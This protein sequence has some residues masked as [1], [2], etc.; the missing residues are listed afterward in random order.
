MTR[1]YF[2]RHAEAMGN[3]REFFQ[4]R[5]DCD[6]SEKGAKQLEKLAERFKTV[7]YDV[8]YS[9]PLIRT[10][11]TAEA[12]NSRLKL[13]IIKDERLIEINGGV[14]EGRKWTEIAE[15]Y[16]K[17]HDTWKNN[18][19]AFEIEDGETMTEVYERMKAAV[20][21]IADKNRGKTVVIVSH[22]CALRNYLSFAEFG[23]PDG[24]SEVGW[25]D[26]TAVSLIEYDDDLTPT[27]IYKNDSSHLP[28]ELSTLAFSRWSKYDEKK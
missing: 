8:I 12:V 3:V 21:D 20:T 17:E 26:N 5:I 27:I 9:S 2:V 23:S 11:K 6:I 18:M 15:K 24:L 16:P 22:G 14:W 1:I 25:S 7:D 19:K 28:H 4:G 13:P 10:M